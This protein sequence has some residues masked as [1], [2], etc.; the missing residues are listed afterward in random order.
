MKRI[1]SILVVTFLFSCNNNETQKQKQLETWN[2]RV[3][4]YDSL[5]DQKANLSDPIDIY[6][7]KNLNGLNITSGVVT[8]SE[9]KDL[10]VQGESLGFYGFYFLVD[11]T[12][13]KPFG[14]LRIHN[15]DEDWSFDS[16]NEKFA[17]IILESNRVSVWDSIHVGL[18]EK[19]LKDFIGDRFHYKKGTMI[20]SELDSYE[21]IFTILNDT[22]NKLTIKNN[23]K[24]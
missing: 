11:E 9:T 14:V 13:G 16:K 17:E 8:H 19:K 2:E 10:C 3:E 5:L 12:I 4:D 23:C 15:S 22:I 21:G 7:L 24:K 6:K 20:Y 1:L 18:S